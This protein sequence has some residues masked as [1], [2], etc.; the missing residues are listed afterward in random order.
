MSNNSFKSPIAPNLNRVADL[1][2]GDAIQLTGQAYPCT[3]QTIV[4]SG[5]VTVAFQVAGPTLPNATIPV[6]WSEFVRPSIYVGMK[7]V[8]MA[9][10]ARLGGVTGLGLGQAPLGAVSNLGALIFVPLGNTAW[11]Q[12]NAAQTV[13]IGGPDGLRVQDETG[14]SI[15]LFSASGI[16]LSSHG[17]TITITASGITL[18]GTEWA[19]HAHTNVQSG[20]S[21]TGPVA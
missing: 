9:A 3:V 19:T 7:G 2:A 11:A 16:T 6:A 15:G 1:R 20:S 14:A 4:S 10:S 18:D 12:T 8:A 5:I 21:E 13:V 17:H